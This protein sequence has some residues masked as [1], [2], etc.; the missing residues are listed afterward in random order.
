MITYSY[1]IHFNDTSMELLRQEE[2]DIIP[3]KLIAYSFWR[4]SLSHDNLLE[5]LILTIVQT[6]HISEQSELQQSLT[7]RG[8][9]IPQAT[10]SRRLKKL[11]IAKVAG[12]YK[13]IDY[14]QPGLPL[15]VNIQVSDYGLIVLQTHP[16]NASSLAYFIDRKYVTYNPNK[17]T[18]SGILGTIA[19]DDTVLMIVKSQHDMEK[20][21]GSLKEDF[22]YL[23][24][25]YTN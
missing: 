11:N 24:M 3:I 10:L 2:L 5:S 7:D 20:I 18:H 16:G 1:F 13:I 14:N 19:G 6:Q 9:D 15:V 8:Y 12:A 21:L 17:P 22:P 4:T 25:P 23:I